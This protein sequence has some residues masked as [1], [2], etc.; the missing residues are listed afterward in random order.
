[1]RVPRAVLTLTPALS[2]PAGEGALRFMRRGRRP[3]PWSTEM[4]LK[5]VSL[6]E[7]A[8]AEGF[9]LRE[10]APG[11]ARRR[12]TFLLAQESN[13]RS[14]FKCKRTFDRASEPGPL[15]APLEVRL[16]MRSVC[17]VALS[18]TA[19]PRYGSASRTP[20][21]ADVHAAR[22]RRAS[23]AGPSLF[24]SERDA[25][26]VARS[27]LTGTGVFGGTLAASGP[28]TGPRFSV[29]GQVGC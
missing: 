7:S 27:S 16:E 21:Q 24:G 26:R 25:C 12:V 2:R 8:P 13:Q 10:S 1:M 20:Q 5:V 22:R 17:A 29:L 9:S 15:T 28:I 18:T 6:G 11:A 4:K 14:A 3:A 23:A 19:A